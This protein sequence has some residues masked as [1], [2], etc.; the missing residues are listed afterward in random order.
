MLIKHHHF[1]HFQPFYKV[2]GSDGGLETWSCLETGLETSFYWSRSWAWK[3]SSRSRSCALKVVVSFKAICQDNRDQN[4]SD[5]KSNEIVFSKQQN[6]DQ[7]KNFLV[8]QLWL[9]KSGIIY[10][11]TCRFPALQSCKGSWVTSFVMSWC[12]R[13]PW[14]TVSCV[15]QLKCEVSVLVSDFEAETPSLV[16]GL[17][18][19]HIFK[20]IMQH[21]ILNGHIWQ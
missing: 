14:S 13:R 3:S 10:L 18:R 9:T 17:L 19:F 7:P 21:K 1:W 4:N 15:F 5:L 2:W 6:D 11:I 16:W 20:Q 8:L 12:P